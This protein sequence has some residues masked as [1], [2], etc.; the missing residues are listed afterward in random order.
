MECHVIQVDAFTK[1]PGQGNPAGVI[2]SGDNYS[3]EQMQEIAK[4]VG[5]NECVFI[6]ESKIGDVKLRYFT[7]GHE[8]PLCGHATMGAVYLLSQ[9]E[10][11]DRNWLI[12][13]Q[14]GLITVSYCKE[15]EL[16]TMEQ[17]PAKFETFA[18]DREELCEAIGISTADLS[19]ELPIVYGNTGSW[20][21]IV[22]VNEPAVLDKMVPDTQRFPDILKEMPH[23]SIH[24]FSVAG[25]EGNQ[26][27][28]RHFSSP[29]SGTIEDSVTGTASGV[30][31]AY[32]LEYRY[33]KE[34]EQRISIVQ[35]KHVEREG[36]LTVLAKRA[37]DGSH[38]VSIT[39]TACKNKEFAIFI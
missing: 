27:E 17:S 26:Y 32:L 34:S 12:E 5:F 28:A 35:G 24:P 23:S 22:P 8:T 4:K 39:G 6:C 15:T 16:M 13:T 11:H 3:T 33:Q 18:G 30:M 10:N 9:L 14:A 2:L 20:T 7:P 31:G 37:A 1:E 21:L 29:F 38:Q 36:T 25:G 19:T